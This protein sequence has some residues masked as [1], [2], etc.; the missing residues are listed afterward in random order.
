MSNPLR[1]KIAFIK[2]VGE[3]RAQ[4]LKD[5]LGVETVE[6]MIDIFPFRYDDRS[7]YTLIK[8]IRH[9]E[10]VQLKGILVSLSRVKSYRA[11][12]VSRSTMDA[13][14]IESRP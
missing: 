5:E 13:G 9:G 10:S 14:F 3:T 4:V 7:V 6:D 11:H 2:G 12:V 1:Q 8:D